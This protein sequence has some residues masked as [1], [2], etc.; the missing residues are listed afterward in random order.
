M[1]ETSYRRKNNLFGIGI[2]ISDK[3]KSMRD[4]IALVLSLGH[5]ELEMGLDSTTDYNIDSCHL[6]N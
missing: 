6:R 5:L 2:L 3:Y 4:R 1:I